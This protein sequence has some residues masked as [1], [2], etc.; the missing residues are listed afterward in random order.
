ML[1]VIFVT[2]L[3]S[4][5][6]GLIPLTFLDGHD[7]FAWRKGLWL[8]LWGFG[9][10]WFAVVIL[11]PA[12]STYNEVSG[13]GAIWFGILFGSLMIIALSTWAYFAIREAR[14]RARSEG[15]GIP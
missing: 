15:A 1:S 6:F 5:V 8:V 13:A 3:E 7:L 4:A 11:H 12:L 14:L 9:L 2:G 10:Y